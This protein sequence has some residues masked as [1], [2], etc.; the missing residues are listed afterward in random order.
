[1]K[2]FVTGSSGHLAYP[3]LERLCR[4]E[5]IEE[6]RGIDIVQP[7][8]T[9][10]KFHAEIGDIR[11]A[12]LNDLMQGCNG[13][14]HLAFVVLRGKMQPETMESINL[15]G[16]MRVFET[17][18]NNGIRHMVHL[19]SAAV[20]GSGENITESSPLNPIKGFL[21]GQHKA[22]LDNWLA[23]NFPEA[24]RLRP[25]IIL[26]PN[27]QP[28]LKFLLRQAC[29]PRLPD[30]QPLLQC[31]HE[32][33]VADAIILALLSEASGPFNLA[34]LDAYSF[35][36]VL[37]N[38]HRF[39]IGLPLPFVR[40]TLHVLWKLTGAGGEPAWVDGMEQT[41]TLDCS[42]ARR[43][44]GW[45]PQFTSRDSIEVTLHETV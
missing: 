42:E 10:A 35:R 6:V 3:L 25:H 17:A 1:M 19:S 40:W 4:H 30:P 2:V 39:T 24:I 28:L 26:G 31:I 27:S 11:T 41:L 32:N 18:K 45:H 33:D 15:E 37:R 7:D 8:F 23:H 36:D 44:L 34:A 14:I 22:T 12:P 21:Y 13:L 38:N 9:H 20:Y 43:I 29:Y 5:E 16:S